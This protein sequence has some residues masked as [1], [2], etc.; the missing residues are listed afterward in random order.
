MTWSPTAPSRRLPCTRLADPRV[1]GGEPARRAGGQDRPRPDRP[2]SAQR[3]QGGHQGRLW[4]HL[5]P[6]RVR[7]DLG[8]GQGACQLPGAARSQPGAGRCERLL[9]QLRRRDVRVSQRA[10]RRHGGGV[11]RHSGHWRHP[12]CDV[13]GGSGGVGGSNTNASRPSSRTPLLLVT[14]SAPVAAGWRSH[15]ALQRSPPPSR[16]SRSCAVA[17]RRCGGSPRMRS[18][19]RTAVRCPPART[20]ASSSRSRSRSSRATRP[21]WAAPSLATS[22]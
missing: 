22:R 7:G 17:R 20:P 9:V 8:C 15:V 13:P 16:R 14:T 12:R 21:A 11:D 5:R 18:P 6:H 4:T 3:R 2:A 10:H 19:G 1:C